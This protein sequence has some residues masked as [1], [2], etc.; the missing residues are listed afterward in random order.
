MIIKSSHFFE[1]FYSFLRTAV[2]LISIS[3][4]YTLQL[5]S[6]KLPQIQTDE[7]LT[8]YVRRSLFLNRLGTGM[9]AFEQLT[10]CRKFRGTEVKMITSVM[11]WPGCY[12]FNRLIHNHTLN[13]VDFILKSN[14][15]FS[16]SQK[17]YI[18]DDVKFCDWKASFCP[19]CVRDDLTKLGYSYWRRFSAP[20]ITVC[21]KHNTV[22]MDRCPFCNKLFSQTA[23]PL[24]VM[25]QGCSG[26]YLNEA[27]SLPND[28]PFAFRHAVMVHEICS[29]P[30]YLSYVGLIRSLRNKAAS[31]IQYLSS[32]SA[33][34]M[35]FLR[36]QMDALQDSLNIYIKINN[37]SRHDESKLELTKIIAKIYDGFSDI[38]GDLR[39]HDF[40]CRSIDSLWSTYQSGGIET[41]HFVEEDFIN[42]LGYWSCPNPCQWSKSDR[43]SDHLETK[44]TRPYRCC[45]LLIS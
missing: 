40:E 22:L 12:G 13:A 25:W 14:Q 21:Y 44:N 11:G 36:Y 7:S 17:Q 24:D 2:P 23:H 45:N 37:A 30:Y 5:P 6:T 18:R 29:S 42:G 32:E 27:V 15:D 28:A 9:K 4:L 39:A 35:N 3:G 33:Q 20:F 19:D 38:V 16:Y 43:S 41:A 34:E 31:V 10:K 8:S 1:R 26:R